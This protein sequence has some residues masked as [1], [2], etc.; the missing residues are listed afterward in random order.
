MINEE[1]KLY[2]KQRDG[3]YKHPKNSKKSISFIIKNCWEVALGF[4][5]SNAG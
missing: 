3:V 5:K 1:Q 2:K 4:L